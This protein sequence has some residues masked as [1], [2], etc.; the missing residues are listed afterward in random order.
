MRMKMTNFVVHETLLVFAL[1]CAATL[2]QQC[3]SQGGGKLCANALCCSKWGY[4][5]STDA[6]CGDGCQSQCPR[7]STPVPSGPSSGSGV[8]SIVTSSMFDRLF[9]H[10]S[11][12]G[13]PA[14]GFYTYNAF[15]SA[16]SSFNGFGT[17]SN[18]DSNKREIAAFFAN[19]AHETTAG[20]YK[21]EISQSSA[22]CSPGQW[23]CASGKKYYGR[24]PLQISWN[25]NYGQA[26]KAIGFDGINNPEIV[27]TD[28]VISF[29]TAIWFWMTP[30]SPKPSCHS[31][32]TG[33]QGFGKTINIIN[34]G[35]ECGN[36][37]P[38]G[39]AA[40]QDRINIYKQYCGI[41]GVQPDTQLTC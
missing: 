5:G 8:G 38:D 6:Y 7:S 22:Y 11:D 41:L 16:A 17:A 37:N 32:I 28:P 24:G 30:Q 35:I 20:C 26:G 21:E 18:A 14:R 27:S 33:G 25:Y 2:A 29:K 13:C 3:G 40:Q 4:C 10:R 34:G 1:L 19:A 9:S 12:G 36:A 15:L 31:A 39:K 23:P